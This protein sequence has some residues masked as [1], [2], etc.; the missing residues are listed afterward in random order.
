MH[1]FPRIYTY[2]F[3]RL[4]HS[5][6]LNVVDQMLDNLDLQWPTGPDLSFDVAFP[7]AAFDFSSVFPNLERGFKNNASSDV[8]TH[9]LTA[10]HMI[11][12]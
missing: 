5:D 8:Q 2:F 10:P 9:L 11:F 3:C 6:V 1:Y 4:P 7:E 12:L